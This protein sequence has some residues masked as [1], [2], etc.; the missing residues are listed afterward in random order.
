[1]SV[2]ITVPLASEMLPD[3][4]AGKLG[5]PGP[6]EKG[7]EQFPV[8]PSVPQTRAAHTRG[9][10]LW[11]TYGQQDDCWSPLGEVPL[12]LADLLL[13]CGCCHIPS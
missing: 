1:M 13:P 3:I 5:K 2:I 6:E 4:L 10:C 12:F 11:S 8:P 7:F 9:L